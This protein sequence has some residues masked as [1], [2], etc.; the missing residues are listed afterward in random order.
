MKY[1]FVESVMYLRK[2]VMNSVE[3]LIP[4]LHSKKHW[5]YHKIEKA[6][7]TQKKEESRLKSLDSCRV[8]SDTKV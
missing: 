5:N 2:I 3:N 8:F 4:K 1:L 7:K 6:K